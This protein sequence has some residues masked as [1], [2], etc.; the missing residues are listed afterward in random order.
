MDVGA[1]FNSRSPGNCQY[2]YFFFFPHP[3]IYKR[4]FRVAVKRLMREAWEMRES[5][6]DFSAA[7]VADNL[8]EWHFTI[9]GANDSDFEGGVYHGRISF[10]TEYPM[11]PPNIIL[12]TVSTVGI[13]K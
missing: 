9:R 10:P 4:F 5:T 11:K 1:Q 6:E 3:F 13:A 12:L 8:F 7:P 2:K